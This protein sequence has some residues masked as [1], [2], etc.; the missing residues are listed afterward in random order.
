MRWD[1][2]TLIHRYIRS[3]LRRCTHHEDTARARGASPRGAL[4]P[5]D[6]PSAASPSVYD[7]LTD[8]PMQATDAGAHAQERD[9]RGREAPLPLCEL[10][11]E[12]VGERGRAVAGG[13][14]ASAKDS[15][16]AHGT[17][18]SSGGRDAHHLASD[19]DLSAWLGELVCPAVG[20][21]ALL[22]V[23]GGRMC[24]HENCGASVCEP[25]SSGA[26]CPV[27][28]DASWFA[29]NATLGK[30]MS[31]VTAVFGQPAQGGHA[32]AIDS[33]PSVGHG[34]GLHGEREPSQAWRMREDP[35]TC[36]RGRVVTAG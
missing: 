8:S 35:H 14:A 1:M 27:C 33:G 32:V 12:D 29:R 20:C 17:S 5:T 4:S 10:M 28:R 36:T 2:L 34:D 21:G 19:A 3:L 23:D 18:S 25:C 26:V 11:P 22:P 9:S 7:A 6:A 13:A 24:R 31:A 15:S 16:A 30:W